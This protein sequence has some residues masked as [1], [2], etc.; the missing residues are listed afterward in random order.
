MPINIGKQQYNKKLNVKFGF[1]NICIPDRYGCKD[2]S[3]LVKNVCG[4][5]ELK[6][7]LNDTR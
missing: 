6:N 2:P 4:L 3:D 5:N 7:I 1:I